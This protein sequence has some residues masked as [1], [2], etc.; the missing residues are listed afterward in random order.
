M[1]QTLGGIESIVYEL[2][3][4]S[5]KSETLINEIRQKNRLP[6]LEPGDKTRSGCGLI[7]VTIT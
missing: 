5:L 1:G 2:E 7:L 3:T 6:E 4:L